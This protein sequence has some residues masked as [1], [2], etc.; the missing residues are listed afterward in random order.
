MSQEMMEALNEQH[1]APFSLLRLFTFGSPPLKASTSR[2]IQPESVRRQIR[3]KR[4]NEMVVLWELILMRLI[5]VRGIEGG[6]EVNNTI[7]KLDSVFVDSVTL[8]NTLSI[9][10]AVHRMRLA[11]SKQCFVGFVGPQNAG[12]STLLNKLF[13][14]RAAAGVRTHTEEPT[15]YDVAEHVVA[16][17]FPGLDS[18]E[19]HRSRF[20][21]FGPMNNLFI[22]VVPYNGSPSES[23][24]ENVRTAYKMEKQAG[25]AARTL[26]CITMCGMD[27][28]KNESFDDD[29]KTDFVGK[30][31][32]ELEKPEVEKDRTLQKLLTKITDTSLSDWY[33]QIKEKEMELKA[34]ILDNLKEED[35]MF[36]DQLS[37]D[38]SR[39]IKGP[40]EVKERIKS[41]LA[42]MQ[43]CS[44]EKLADLF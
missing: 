17:D 44:K 32:K 41:Y 43:I 37:P 29:Y 6:L 9:F 25:N 31:R 7:C 11:Y 13:D 30:I 28:F 3:C 4:N 21:E 2:Q 8:R 19:D 15:R 16:M 35:F 22:Y 10:R 38:P 18:L 14:K 5:G 42:E 20:E 33:N 34:Y 1:M 36:T 24:V 12:K 26:F 40:K 23:L 27:H 39:G